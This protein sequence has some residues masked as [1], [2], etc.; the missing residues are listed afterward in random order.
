VARLLWVP[1]ESCT[2]SRDLGSGRLLVPSLAESLVLAMF[3]P[4]RLVIIGFSKN[5][6]LAMSALGWIGKMGPSLVGIDSAP[7][8]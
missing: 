6:E 4:K 2:E 1:C 3:V 5:S 8:G 7:W